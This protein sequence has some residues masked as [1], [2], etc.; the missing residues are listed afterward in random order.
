MSGYANV[1]VSLI[2]SCTG[3]SH[4]PRA[5]ITNYLHTTFRLRLA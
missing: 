4:G 5:I 2:W 3:P 1:R